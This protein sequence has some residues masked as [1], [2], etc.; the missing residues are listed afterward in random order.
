VTGFV[1]SLRLRHARKPALLDEL[2]R[3]GF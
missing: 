3:A 2:S 1:A